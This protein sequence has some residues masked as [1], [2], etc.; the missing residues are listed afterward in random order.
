MDFMFL[1]FA[2]DKTANDEQQK[3][4]NMLTKTMLKMNIIIIYSFSNIQLCV[5]QK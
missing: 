3:C 5:K 1:H 2:D 4:R